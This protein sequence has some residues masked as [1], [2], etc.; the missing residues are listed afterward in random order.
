M[1]HRTVTLRHAKQELLV[2]VLFYFAAL[3]IRD[4][5][6]L[7]QCIVNTVGRLVRLSKLLLACKTFT[8]R[9]LYWT[10]SSSPVFRMVFE[11]DEITH[12]ITDG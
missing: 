11:P 5:T 6:E 10:F 2:S 4:K 8:S 12:H 3:K 1:D 9:S 7:I